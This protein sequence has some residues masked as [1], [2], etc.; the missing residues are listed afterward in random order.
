MICLKC[1]SH[2]FR[3]KKLST[4]TSSEIQSCTNT[5]RSGIQGLSLLQCLTLP[6]HP[7]DIHLVPSHNMDVA[8]NIIHSPKRCTDHS[9]SLALKRNVTTSILSQR[10]KMSKKVAKKTCYKLQFFWGGGGG[11]RSLKSKNR[12]FCAAYPHHTCTCINNL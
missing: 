1:N 3:H 12:K 2:S 7:S 6:I 9:A 5:Q 8:L 11:G 4:T 10:L